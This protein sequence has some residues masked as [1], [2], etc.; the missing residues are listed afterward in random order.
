ME[1]K[2][3]ENIAES[4][5]NLGDS[6]SSATEGRAA[7]V[8]SVGFPAW[9]NAITASLNWSNALL[10]MGN[11]NC[12]SGVS[13]IPCADRWKSGQPIQ[14]SSCL[15]CCAIAPAVTFNSWAAFTKL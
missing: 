7:M 15:T 1:K 12:D 2:Q 8:I 5:G 11:A 9:C 13:L 10:S 3:S 4:C 6:H 14:S